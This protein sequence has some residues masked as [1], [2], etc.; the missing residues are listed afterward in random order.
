[1]RELV[2]NKKY[3]KKNINLI[4]LIVGTNLYWF[5]IPYYNF[6]FTIAEYY[7]QSNDKENTLKYLN[8]S[9]DYAFSLCN[10]QD[11]DEYDS[12]WLKGVKHTTSKIKNCE[13]NYKIFDNTVFDF[14]RDSIEFNEVKNR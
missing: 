14:I 5:N 2:L 3:L 10:S 11:A 6:A 13:G 4:K 12:Y 9:T 8:E 7:A 1:M